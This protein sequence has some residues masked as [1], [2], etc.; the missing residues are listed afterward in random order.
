V[1]LRNGWIGISASWILP[2]AVA[3]LA[4]PP[5]GAERG[6][7]SA[8]YEALQARLAK[9]WNTWDVQSVTTEV[10]LP[11]GLAIRVGVQRRSAVSGEASLNDALIGRSGRDAEQVFPGAHTWDGSYTD[12]RLAWQGVEM[13]LQSAHVGSDLVMLATPLSQVPAGHLPPTISFT[14][15]YLW[16]RP[17]TVETVGERIVAKRAGGEVAVFGV[18]EKA[19]L[20]GIP[21]VGPYL[22]AQ[23]DQAAGISTGKRRSVAEIQ[24]LI[25]ERR[26]V[27]EKS[28]AGENKAV[29]DAIESTLGWDTIYEPEQDRVVSV[30]S[31]LWSTSWGGYVIFEWDTF[32]A[33]SLAAIGDRD[34]AYA[35]AIETL[36]EA[37]PKGLVPNYGRGGGW[38]SFDRSEPPVGAITV[39]AL[40]GQFHD[41]W[42]LEDT[43]PALLQWNRWWEE[44]RRIGDSLVWGS[45][46]RNPPENVD[47]S[48]RGTRQGAIFESG[49][50]NSPMYDAAQFDAGSGRLMMADVGL[51]SEY[52][53]DCDAL[54]AIAG[55]LGKASEE[56]ELKARAAHYRAS[57]SAMWDER[58]GMFLNRDLKTG[59]LSARVSP[60][61]FYPLLARA[62]TESQ[63]KRMVAEHLLNPREFW[64]DWVIPATP[65]D[66]AAFKDQTYWRGR[67]WGPMNYLVYLGLRNYDLGDARRQLAEKSLKLFLKEWREKGHV[68]ENYNAVTGLGDDVPNSDPF[69]HWGALLGLI[70]YREAEFPP[71]GAAGLE[72]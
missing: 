25:E 36:R 52:V 31:R 9:G 27:Y 26:L 40:Y 17:G 39:E 8:Q 62:A 65:R 34:L 16:N 4:A 19:P 43:F 37:T 45:D 67:I 60:T 71:A 64:G 57:L 49:L 44:N 69:Y 18:G 61:N 50:D 56:E 68:H 33:A 72:R 28:I 13:R 2:L 63:A 54:A 51:M 70:G 35:D 11:E 23:L 58:L 30:V 10:L 15:G 46:G 47:D 5:M 32:F 12:L 3:V 53:A 14:V 24:G 22:V 6:A 41:R 20:S 7:R 29:L 48:S 59:K 55:V 66:D 21:A 38:K 42:L 1:A